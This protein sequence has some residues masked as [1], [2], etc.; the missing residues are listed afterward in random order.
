MRKLKQDCDYVCNTCGATKRLHIGD[1]FT[2]PGPARRR[3][4]GKLAY[5]LGNG[6]FAR[7][8]Q[9]LKRVG[10]SFTIDEVEYLDR[11]L[12]V[13][14]RGADTS[15]IVRAEAFRHVRKIVNSA[16]LR[17][18]SQQDQQGKAA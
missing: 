9:H 11:L 7:R 5:G 12:S 6:K 16:R 4:S 10:M 18:T 3:K 13:V 2:C 8:T 17:G 14:A 1:D 15:I